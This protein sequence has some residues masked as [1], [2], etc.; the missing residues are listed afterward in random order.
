MDVNRARNITQMTE[1]T[2][3]AFCLTVADDWRVVSF[4]GFRRSKAVRSTGKAN[5]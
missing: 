3:A 4:A 2:S 5:T 1:L